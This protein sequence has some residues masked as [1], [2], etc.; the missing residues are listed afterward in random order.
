MTDLFEYEGGDILANL[1]DRTITGLLIP[2]NELG[3]TN[4]GRFLV[5]ASTIALP[6]D[7][8][9]VGLNLD[10][11]RS[12]PV[13]RATRVWEEA[14]GIMASFKIAETPEGDAAL[15]DALNPAGIRRRLSGEFHAVIK[16]GKATAGNLWGA[17]LVRMGAFPSAMVLAADTTS[18]SQYVS[19]YTDENGVTWR[20][21]EDSTTTTTQ[22]ATGEE[23]VTESTV[24]ETIE[25]EP[26][27][28]EPIPVAASA[29]TVPSTLTPPVPAGQ[30]SPRD[31]SLSQVLAS[32][33]AL[34]TNPMDDGARAVLAAMADVPMTGAGALPGAGVLRENWL[35]KLYQGIPYV[36]QFIQ[37]GTLG[38]DITAAGKAGFRVFRGTNGAAS[39]IPGQGAWGGFPNQLNGYQGS[40]DVLRSV[41]SRFALANAIDRAYTD[42]PGGEEALASFLQLVI[43]DHLIWSDRI[44]REDLISQAVPVAAATAKYP[45]NYPAALGQ[46]IQGILSV[47]KRKN[48]QRNDVPTFAIANDA[49]FE[50]LAY[51]AG[52]DQN[53][54]EFVSIALST[55]GTATVDGNVEVVNGD[56]GITGTPSV[57]VGAQAAI[58]FDELPNGPLVIDA[59]ELARG[60]FDKATHGYLQRFWKRPEAFAHIG[61]PDAWAQGSYGRGIL[62]KVGAGILR[63]APTDPLAAAAATAGAAPAL[64]GAVGGTVVDGGIT[65]TRIA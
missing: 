33:V 29:A 35:G 44:A 3:Q 24:T 37:L 40:S 52:G 7:P 36:R 48:D 51:A 30:T 43:E 8:S 47:K 34:K 54:P 64:P 60:G 27:M 21:V 61:T 42:L 53:L 46:L 38:T 59:L 26:P 56:T 31:I 16:A 14:K 6:D 22:T 49:A 45:D 32:I 62:A 5:E 41:L 25:G 19:E 17:A 12:H 55:A 9:V 4:A 2:F 39:N 15:A 50:Q 20:R 10:H 65:W 63:G 28:P 58:D 18:S 1:E 57:V 13:G 23:R 11:E